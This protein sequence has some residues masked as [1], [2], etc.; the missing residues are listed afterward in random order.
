MDED[1]PPVRS[2]SLEIKEQETYT[3][4]SM[5]GKTRPI[6]VTVSVNSKPIQFPNQILQPTTISLRTYT[7]ECLT[8]LGTLEVQVEHS[9][10]SATL[11]LI[12]VEEEGP[13]LF[14][15]NWLEKIRLNW[16]HICNITPNLSLEKVL[17]YHSQDHSQLFVKDLDV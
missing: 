7:G 17:E 10:Q 14:G 2:P 6:L 13:N 5:A 1:T 9:S 16:S 4:F 8:I 12:V 3:L 15:Q 11:P